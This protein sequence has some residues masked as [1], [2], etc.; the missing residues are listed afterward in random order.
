MDVNNDEKWQ[1]LSAWSILHFVSK[2]LRE[3]ASSAVYALP[4]FAVGINKWIE[5]NHVLVKILAG[6]TIYIVLG[7]FLRYW[8]YRFQLHANRIEIKTGI[9]ERKYTDLPFERIQ[10]VK[11]DQPFYY[12]W[13]KLVIVT[14]DTAGSSKEEASIVAVTR[15]YAQDLK[16]QVMQRKQSVELESATGDTEISHAESDEKILNRRSLKD[17]VLHGIT[18]NRVWIL[19]GAAAPFYDDVYGAVFGW[20]ESMQPEIEQMLGAGSSQFWYVSVLGLFFALLIIVAMALLSI[21]GSIFIF[22]GYTL[23]KEGDRYIRRSGLINK[24]EVGMKRSRVQMVKMKQDWLD[25]ILKRINLYL[26]QNV[27][28]NEFERNDLKASNKL[29]VPSVKIDEANKITQDVFPAHQTREIEFNSIS[30]RYLIHVLWLKLLPFYLAAFVV[31]I[32]SNAWLGVPLSVGIITLAV[33]AAYIRWKRWGIAFDDNYIYVRKGLLGVEYACFPYDKIQ[34]VRFKQSI[35]MRRKQLATP[36]FVLASGKARVPFL[37]QSLASN[38]LNKGL[39]RVESE[40]PK[41]M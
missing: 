40:K 26:E 4:V 30:P 32:E 36:Y 35:F 2:Q 5:T 22:Y 9:F 3:L 33:T 39:Y 23:S 10:N 7:G 19:I 17:L 1:R 12:R 38:I 8:F 6:L 37:P 34:Q 29:L 11:I 18:N 21:A 41:W 14:L 28:G 31:L 25:V 24:Q 27:T 16:Q 13:L 20:I 15:D